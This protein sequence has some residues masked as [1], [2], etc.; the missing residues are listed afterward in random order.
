MK[1]STVAALVSAMASTATGFS[2]MSPKSEFPGRFGQY[3]KEIDDVFEND[4]PATFME[5]QMEELHELQDTMKGS[6]EQIKEDVPAMTTFRRASP[7][8]EVMEHPDKFEV[9]V[10]IPGYN[11]KDIFVD[12]KAGGRL[13]TVTGMHQEEEEGRTLSARFQQNFSLDPS[14]V[15]EEMTAD[16]QGENLI[17]TAPR[18]VKRL[19]ESRTIPIRMIGEAKGKTGGKHEKKGKGGKGGKV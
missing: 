1:F 17:L 10:H 4:W 7:R 12:L 9:V 11:P 18:H 15:T 16:I 3:L 19:P 14:I 6:M 2:M 8:Y 13:L 5:K